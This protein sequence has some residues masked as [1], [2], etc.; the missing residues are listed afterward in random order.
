LSPAVEG[1][2]AT[3]PLHGRAAP[4]ARARGDEA[5]YRDLANRYRAMAQSL[6]FEDKTAWRNDDVMM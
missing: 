4:L 5:A 2:C 3:S 6:G 1:F